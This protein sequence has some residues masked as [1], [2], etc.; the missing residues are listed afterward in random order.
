MMQDFKTLFCQHFNCPSAE[1]QNRVFHKCLRGH[2]RI[3]APLLGL[4]FPGYFDLD[5]T[6]INHLGSATG[7]RGVELELAAFREANLLHHS[8]G[9]SFLGLR[10]S[11]AK[12]AKLA[13]SLLDVRETASAHG[14][15][16]SVMNWH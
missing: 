7:R 1:Y 2:A 14:V 8:I 3:L 13:N 6:L 15:I 10:I 4:L 9:R 5:F 11:S 12:A 16:R